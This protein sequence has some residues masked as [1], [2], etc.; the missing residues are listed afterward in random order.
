MK[1]ANQMFPS[2]PTVI[3]SGWEPPTNG[4]G[5]GKT[6]AIPVGVIRTI[7]W[8]ALRLNQRFPSGPAVIWTA[9]TCRTSGTCADGDDGHETARMRQQPKEYR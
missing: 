9:G 7:A 3:P 4:F 2:G 1:S 6:L 5:T 8:P